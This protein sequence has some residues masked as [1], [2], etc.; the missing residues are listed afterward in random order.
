MK[1]NIHEITNRN[2]KFVVIA[3]FYKNEWLMVRHKDRTTYEIP[4]GHIEAGESPDDAAKRELYEETGAVTFE[5][6]AVGD[7]SVTR[8][9]KSSY[10]RLYIA[11][12]DQLGAL[13]ESEIIEIKSIN[14]QMVWT[15]EAIQPILFSYIKNHIISEK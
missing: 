15:Y 7:Y 13:P 2:L 3:A 4:G 12:I 5:L 10:G 11:H 8:E 14:N 9:N 1:V 6:T